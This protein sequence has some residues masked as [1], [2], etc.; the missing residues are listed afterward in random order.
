M[1]S[2]LRLGC[3]ISYTVTVDEHFASMTVSASLLEILGISERSKMRT[4]VCKIAI[5]CTCI[6][7]LCD[8]MFMICYM[9][10]PY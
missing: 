3:L 7:Q 2:P 10:S 1:Q 5:V 4:Q 6:R 9:H 8:S